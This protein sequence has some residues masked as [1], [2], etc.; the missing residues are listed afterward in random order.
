MRI[1]RFIRLGEGVVDLQGSSTPSTAWNPC[2]GVATD[3]DFPVLA[4]TEIP[5]GRN[6]ETV[7]VQQS[8]L[9][10]TI[11]CSMQVCGLVLG[12]ETAGCRMT[13]TIYLDRL[14]GMLGFLTGTV[15]AACEPP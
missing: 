13:P 3:G 5:V 8:W 6:G 10:T 11:D 12:T 14:F 1:P 9:T 4:S 7:V 2:P 15:S